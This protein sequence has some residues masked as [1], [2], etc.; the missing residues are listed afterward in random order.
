MVDPKNGGK[1]RKPL[2]KQMGQKFDRIHARKMQKKL[3]VIKEVHKPYD[4]DAL[5]QHDDRIKSLLMDQKIQRDNKFKLRKKADVELLKDL[6]PTIS[7][8]ATII[9]NGVTETVNKDSDIHVKISIK[10]QLYMYNFKQKGTKSHIFTKLTGHELVH[11]EIYDK[12]E[13][14]ERDIPLSNISVKKDNFNSVINLHQINKTYQGSFLVRLD[15]LR[16]EINPYK[17][18]IDILRAKIQKAK[19]YSQM[20]KKSNLSVMSMD[21]GDAEED[22]TDPDGTPKKPLN[23]W[24]QAEIDKEKQKAQILERISSNTGIGNDYLKQAVKT[25]KADREKYEKEKE[26]GFV[27]NPVNDID[28][29]TGKP[30]KRVTQSQKVLRPNRFDPLP[31]ISA[32]DEA[33]RTMKKKEAAEYMHEVKK[34]YNLGEIGEN[35][36][37]RAKK[38]PKDQMLAHIERLENKARL[39]EDLARAKGALVYK[40]NDKKLRGDIMKSPNKEKIMAQLESDLEVEEDIDNMYFDAINAK[41]NILENTMA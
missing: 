14:M 8:K 39:K 19:E 38:L 31:K 10:D 36:Q 24:M 6:Q 17:S 40:F 7:V 30:L 41:L 22:E 37:K 34:K 5:R 20:I 25:I 15:M 13:K 21:G 18:E 27:D 26:S 33:K 11:L 16:T 2:W 3:A 12:D 35:F 1:R 9:Q 28:T 4:Y 32:M 23:K 29:N